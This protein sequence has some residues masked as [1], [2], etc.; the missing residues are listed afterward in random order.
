MAASGCKSLFIGFES[1]N[2]RNL[3]KCHKRQNRI[4]T[5]DETIA[6][7]RRRGIMVNASLVFGFDEDDES[8]F[9]ATLDWLIRNRVATMTGHILTPYPGTRLYKQLLSEGRI[10]DHDLNH[11]NTAHAVFTPKQITPRKL[12]LSYRWIYEQ[13]YS[14]PNIFRRWPT[15]N[16]PLAAFLEFNLLYRKFGKVTCILG[17]LFGMRN[18]AK[19]AKAVA[20]PSRRPIIAPAIALQETTGPRLI[21]E[22]RVI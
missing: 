2:Q 3:L 12:E 5:Y 6:K 8:T 20:F 22:E 16:G 11:Y 17:K 4:E 7:I 9:P 21:H 19:L 18:L 13:F 1:V 14:W 10:I 15:A